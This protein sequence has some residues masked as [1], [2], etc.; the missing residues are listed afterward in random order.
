MVPDAIE[1]RGLRVLG[2]HGC[3]A[4]ERARDQP[5]EVDLDVE[6]DV[7]AAA[8]SDD[9]ADTVDYGALA[10]AVAAV[11][12]GEHAALLERLAARIADQVL[13]DARVRSVTV[14]VRKLRPPVPVDLAT[15]GVRLTRTR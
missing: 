13:A 12:G 11:V 6:L 7:G 1:L 14:T 8:R 9:V 4:E 2:R 5:F 10:E 15:A 3:L